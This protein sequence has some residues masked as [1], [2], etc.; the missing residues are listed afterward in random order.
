MS[1][2]FRHDES[3]IRRRFQHPAT[4]GSPTGPVCPGD[5]PTKATGPRIRE[6]QLRIWARVPCWHSVW[7]VAVTLNIGAT[8]MSAGQ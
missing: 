1:G 6:A 3:S 2:Q 7:P 8:A 4:A 5:L